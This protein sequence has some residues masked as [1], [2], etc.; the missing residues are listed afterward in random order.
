[1]TLPDSGSL[2]ITALNYGREATN[3][4]VDLTQVP[5]GIPADA[6]SG[7]NA[8]DAVSGEGAGSVSS[9]GGLQIDLEALQGRTI[10][11]QRQ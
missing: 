9:A 1:M 2:A 7:S 4:E 3:V 6:L 10:V 11:V 5:P 8:V